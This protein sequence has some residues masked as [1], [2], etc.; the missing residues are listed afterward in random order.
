MS[1]KKPTRLTVAADGSV[2]LP[3]EMM[4]ALELKPGEQVELRL[5]TR[6]KQIHLERHVDDPWAEAM[7]EKKEKGFEDLM[8][9]QKA[10]EEEAER[11]F[12][13]RRHE[14]PAPKKPEDDP[15]Y[16]R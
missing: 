11:L 14:K 1:K 4:E 7:R 16:W 15:G 6:R 5:D 13:K 3:P 2:R 10:R 9:D 12:E 8:S